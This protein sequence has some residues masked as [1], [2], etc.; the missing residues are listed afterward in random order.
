MFVVALGQ[1]P[2]TPPPQK[3][4]QKKRRNRPNGQQKLGQG[5]F[6]YLISFYF[7]T[8]FY[9]SLFLNCIELPCRA[10]KFSTAQCVTQHRALKVVTSHSIRV[11]KSLIFDRFQES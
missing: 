8:R 10:L 3:K 9:P 4:K 5:Q 1:T 11:H 7:V 6:I 2:E